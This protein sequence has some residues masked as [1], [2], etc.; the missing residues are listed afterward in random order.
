MK[1]KLPT[2]EQLIRAHSKARVITATPVPFFV[3]K[4]GAIRRMRDSDV[5]E[6]MVRKYA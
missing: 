3:E 1:T 2:V 5:I 6:Q 4:M